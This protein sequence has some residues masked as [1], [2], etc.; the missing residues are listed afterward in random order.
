MAPSYSPGKHGS[1]RLPAEYLEDVPTGQSWH[2]VC[3]SP[4][5]YRPNPQLSQA[6][7]WARLW[8]LPGAHSRHALCPVSGMFEP[9]GQTEH[10][11]AP[12]ALWNW[13]TWQLW[14]FR[15]PVPVRYAPVLQDVHRLLPDVPAYVP[16]AHIGQLIWPGRLWYR[17]PE[18]RLQAV[19]R[20]A[21]W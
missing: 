15:P 3:P 14:Q 16:I 6:V 1:H 10:V 7:F 13:P 5:E 19:C 20:G 4:E 17:P 11:L 18:H 9:G 21:A 2:T 12:S 8:Y